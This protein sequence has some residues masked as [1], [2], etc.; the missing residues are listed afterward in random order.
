MMLNQT[1]QLCFPWSKLAPETNG[2]S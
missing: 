2:V 1:I